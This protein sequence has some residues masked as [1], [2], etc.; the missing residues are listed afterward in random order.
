MHCRQKIDAA[1][2]MTASTSSKKKGRRAGGVKKRA[3]SR[4]ATEAEN[5]LQDTLPAKMLVELLKNAP[6]VHVCT[7]PALVRY[8]SSLTTSHKRM[9]CC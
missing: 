6:T 2:Q 5:L 8:I 1:E 4:D 9:C 7:T 3:E